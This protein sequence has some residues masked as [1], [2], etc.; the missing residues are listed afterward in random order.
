MPVVIQR[1][2]GGGPVTCAAGAHG[3][4]VFKD[5]R[6]TVGFETREPLW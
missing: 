3:L 2:R 5:V 4:Q 6:P 1:A